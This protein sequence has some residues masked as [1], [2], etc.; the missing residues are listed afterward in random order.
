[1]N[2]ARLNSEYRASRPGARDRH[3]RDGFASRQIATQ[4]SDFPRLAR[5]GSLSQLARRCHKYRKHTG[6]DGRSQRR[7]DGRDGGG[8]GADYPEL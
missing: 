3:N 8:R 1:V 2:K 4:I 6:T 7:T 5:L